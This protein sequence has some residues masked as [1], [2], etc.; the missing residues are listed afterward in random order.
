MVCELMSE[1]SVAAA[2]ELPVTTAKTLDRRGVSVGRGTQV[3]LVP[4]AAGPHLFIY[5][6]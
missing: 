4:S 6:A 3:N 5:A 2:V 1:V